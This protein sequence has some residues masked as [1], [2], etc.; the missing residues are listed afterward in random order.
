MD[1]TNLTS[2]HCSTTCRDGA[3][4]GEGAVGSGLESLIMSVGGI[5]AREGLWRDLLE[6][7]VVKS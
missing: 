1:E 4:L 2:S 7:Q 5:L 3:P 6:S